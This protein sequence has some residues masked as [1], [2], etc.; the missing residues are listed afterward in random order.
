M[1]APPVR[2]PK[3]LSGT[4]HHHWRRLRRRHAAPPRWR[5]ATVYP[6]FVDLDNSTRTQTLPQSPPDAAD[7]AGPLQRALAVLAVRP[8]ALITDVDGTISPIAA[9]P[10][11]AHVLPEARQALGRL[12]GLLDLVAVVSGRPAAAVAAL[13]GVPGLTYIGNHGLDACVDGQPTILPD[14]VAWVP[15]IE[16]ALEAVRSRVQVSG[17]LVEP[18]GPSGSIHYRLCQDPPTVR[19]RILDTLAGLPESSGLRIEDGRMVVNLLPPLH[20]TK[21]SA[22]HRL[23]RRHGLSGL[24]YLGDDVTDAHAFRSLSSLSEDGLATLSIAVTAPETP[25]TVRRLAD[26]SV[27]SVY[28]AADLLARIASALSSPRTLPRGGATMHPR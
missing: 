9:R 4:Q 12:H 11:E 8:S 13:V 2:C 14:A 3:G 5:G 27:A 24:V 6:S 18:K 20:V 22:V 7:R 16:R 17:L 23:V 15:R 25:H 10:E 21:G 26:A 19:R 28:E 1:G